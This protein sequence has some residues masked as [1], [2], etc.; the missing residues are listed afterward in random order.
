MAEDIKE[1]KKRVAEVATISAG[2]AEIG[3]LIADVIHKVGKDGIVTVEEGQSLN[4]ESEVVEGFTIDRGFVSPY[5]VT[6]TTRMEAVYAKP[7]II[8]TDKKVSNVQEFLPLLEQLA[9]A[10]KKD[11]VLIADD[12]EGEARV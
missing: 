4:L 8:I 11:L 12:V 9:Q 6:D 10:G 7:A 3:A 5:F 2:D 1:N